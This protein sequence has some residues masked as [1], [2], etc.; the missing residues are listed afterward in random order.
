MANRPSSMDR[1][2]VAG[3][4]SL[5]P[6]AK[7]DSDSLYAASNNAETTLRTG[8]S[9]NGKKI[10][11][12]DASSFPESGLL[13]IGPKSG[14]GEAE[15]IYYGSRTNNSFLNL[16]RGFSGSRQ[17]QW[18]S[19]SWAT[20][21][22]TAEPHNA[23]KDAIIKIEQTLGLANNPD[24]GTL[25]RRLKDLELKFLSP[26]ASFRAF[27]RVVRPAK[28]V[29]FQNFSE[30]DVIRYFWDFGDGSQS[31][32]ENPTHIYSSEGVYTVK[33]HV[34]TSLGAQNIATKKNY[35]T[36]SYDELPS[37]FYVRRVSG[38]KYVFTDQTDGDIVQRF[39]VFGDGS[40]H[41]EL[42]PNKHFV[43]HEYESPGIYSPSLLVV[44]ASERIRRI[45]L[46]ESVEVE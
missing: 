39:W 26:K 44:F 13:R 25:N 29:R 21:S 5:F 37:F 42:N 19:G 3:D 22:V 31:L 9:Y 14:S 27:P 40:D 32:E 33:L 18:P 30:G 46:N 7:D 11:V 10:I 16:Q 4:L 23:V 35:I 1:G 8:L 34:I 36:V 15:L 41:V 12:E 43:E 24:S 38:R 2:Y 20:N 6:E 45:F 28:A 17:N